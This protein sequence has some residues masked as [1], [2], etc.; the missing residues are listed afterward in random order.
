MDSPFPHLLPLIVPRS[1]FS[2]G[3]FPARHVNLRH[4]E[5]AVTWVETWRQDNEPKLTYVN[6]ERC[7]EIASHGLDVH[8][9]A[10]ANLRRETPEL[11]THI[12]M[13][14]D[15][16]VFQAMMHADA[17][18]SSRLLLLPE[19]DRIFPQG[20]L[21]GI[22]ER[23]CGIVVPIDAGSKNL[24]EVRDLVRRCYEDTQQRPMLSGLYERKMFEI[25][26]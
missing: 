24:D 26:S 10:M 19:W 12:K 6:I 4:A 25:A 15:R 13:D 1:Y 7:D 23:S 8:E 9:L 3:A 14:G 22:P 5:L 17:L 18:G 20:Y 2:S 21:F 16:I 11:G